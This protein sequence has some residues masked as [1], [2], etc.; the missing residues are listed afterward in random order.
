MKK[1]T[2]N[3][4]L[5][6]IGAFAVM[7]LFPIDKTNPPSD[8]AKDFITIENP[9]SPIAD[10][11]KNACYDCHSYHTEYPWYTNVQPVGWWIQG[12]YRGAREE[13]NF[14]EWSNYNA[15]RKAHKMKEA[16]EE[17][18]GRDMPLKSYVNMHPEA[19]LSDE[20]VKMLVD[21]FVSREQG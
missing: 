20:E 8:P 11:M 15:K 18:E 9:P 6:V 10:L 1:R 5:A 3:I 17:V 7:Q 12:H 14:S 2:R 19:K 16:S 13:L 21:Y 4:S